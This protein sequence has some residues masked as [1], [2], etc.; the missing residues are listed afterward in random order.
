M[1]FKVKES[2]AYFILFDDLTSFDHRRKFMFLAV[3]VHQSGCQ[4]K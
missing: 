1:C 2:V 3:S 4:G